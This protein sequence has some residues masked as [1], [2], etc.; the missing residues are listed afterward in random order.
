MI[1][2]FG[3]GEEEPEHREI[4]KI[5]M[6]ALMDEFQLDNFMY[7]ATHYLFTAPIRKKKL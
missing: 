2:F 7:N 6:L 5:N 1:L 3:R 4:K